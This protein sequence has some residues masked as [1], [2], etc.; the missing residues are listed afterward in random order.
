M[1]QPASGWGTGVW[2]GGNLML[3]TGI[4]LGPILL[5]LVALLDLPYGYYQLLRVIVFCT[6]V[7]LAIHE[8]ERREGFWFWA[9]V[10]CALVYNPVFRLS[11]GREIWPLI[12]L[13]T[14][15]LYAAHFLLYAKNAVRSRKPR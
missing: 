4:W 1:A 5:L 13:A 7:Y 3:R 15:A 14:A 9:F 10:V 12:N 2:L 8:K 6:S 11:F